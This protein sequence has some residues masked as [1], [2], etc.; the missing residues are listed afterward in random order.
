MMAWWQQLVAACAS[1]TV[2]FVLL[3]LVG[4]WVHHMWDMFRKFNRLLDQFL[5]DEDARPPIPSLMDQVSE[6]RA[7]QVRLADELASHVQWH[8]APGTRPA[9]NGIVDPN[10]R[11]RRAR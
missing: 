10:H 8:G 7:E 9:G 5:G 2:I 6:V 4:K 3:G 11:A 1:L